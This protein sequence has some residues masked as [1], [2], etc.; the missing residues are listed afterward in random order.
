MSRLRATKFIPS[1]YQRRLL[2]IGLGVLLVF[3]APLAQVTHLTVAKGGEF[4]EAAERKLLNERWIRTIRGTVYDRKGRVLARD[5]AS[6]EVAVDYQVLIGKW[7]YQQATRWARQITPN[8]SELNAEQRQEIVQGHLQDFESRVEMMWDTLGAM[9]GVS[10]SEIEQRREAIIDQVR[11]LNASVT[12]AQRRALERELARGEVLSEGEGEPVVRTADVRRPIREERTHH[13]ILRDVPDSVG[14]KLRQLIERTEAEGGESTVL[15]GLHVLDS[16]RREFPMETVDVAFD[17]SHL[18]GP[19]RGPGADQIGPRIVRVQG[20]GTHVLGWMRGRVYREDS[21]RR[22]AERLRR[23]GYA[24]RE[25]EEAPAELARSLG[26]DRG[27]YLPND[28]VGAAGLEYALEFDLRGSRGVR[29]RH[30]DTG[31]VETTEPIDGQDVILT[32]DAALQARL[33]ALF[34]PDLGLA[35]AQ[36]WHRPAR[37]DENEEPPSKPLDI[38]LGTPLNGSIVVLDVR[39]GQ[40]LSLVSAPTFTR[41]RLATSYGAMLED[42]YGKPLTNRAIAEAYAPGSIVKPLILA[43][44]NAAGRV[45]PGERID[46][47]GHF[48]PDK[49]LLYRCWIYKQFNSTHTAKLGHEPNC[50]EALA[51]S[52][53]IYFFELGRR[54]GQ[55]GVYDL[56]TRLGVGP[57][58]DRWGLG[59]GLEYSGALPRDP[60]RSTLDEAILM[61][62]GQGPIAWT[63]LHAADA[64]A[65]LAR[66]GVR[67]TPRIRMDAP[68]ERKDLGW[69]PVIVRE[70]L[71]GLKASASTAI[72]T[73]YTIPFP[74]PDGSVRRERIFDV[75]GITVWAKSGT[76]DVA[77][78]RADFGLSGGPAVYDGDH[79]WCVLLAGVADVTEYAIAVVVDHG[80]SGGRCAGPIANQ[81][82]RALVREGYLPDL[83]PSGEVGTSGAGDMR[84]GTQTRARADQR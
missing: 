21:Q 63:P 52:C 14:F 3:M 35:V 70:A 36:P 75:P 51:C 65:T 15:P 58:A 19:L 49:P 8:W 67:I 64:Y 40:I 48:F 13:V 10:R 66:G 72:G 57:S 74:M 69:S 34:D 46:C 37:P 28:L 62:I 84:V 73:T 45:S 50:V 1:M 27:R 6:F 31:E 25:S 80:G 39:T 17:L 5:Q 60:A 30:L 53:N 20:V 38:P 54:L 12:E 32:L 33:Q 11:F 22:E 77:P 26:P 61:G 76:A 78:F 29:V 71:E 7:A 16:V 68:A 56:Y 2:L 18:P 83:S 59:I 47:V 44:A 55:R 43:G 9:A 24:H 4:R 79:A 81:V 82:V 23:A 41:D 42:R